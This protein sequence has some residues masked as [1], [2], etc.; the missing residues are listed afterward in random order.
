MNDQTID[1]PT[2]DAPKKSKK[3]GCAIFVVLGIILFVIVAVIVDSKGPSVSINGDTG[4]IVTA[5]FITG[6]ITNIH[7]V[8]I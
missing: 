3:M 6:I 4:T 2:N 8:A 5:F 1:K 7:R